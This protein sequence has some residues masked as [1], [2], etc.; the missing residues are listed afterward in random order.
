MEEPEEDRENIVPIQIYH[1]KVYSI[2]VIND[3]NVRMKKHVFLVSIFTWNAYI[4]RTLSSS[5]ILDNKY[6]KIWNSVTV[7]IFR[8]HSLD[9]Q[10][11]NTS[12]LRIRN[13]VREVLG[14]GKRK[15]DFSGVRW[16]RSH[17]VVMVFWMPR[18]AY[19]RVQSVKC[20]LASLRDDNLLLYAEIWAW[21][22]SVFYREFRQSFDTVKLMKLPIV[23][24]LWFSIS[25]T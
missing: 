20:T 16:G 3:V 12:M 13:W 23:E 19:N 17:Q 24:Y 2:Q 25:F 4:Y 9:M 5:K 7:C 1:F 10:L 8:K 21:T 11:F 15:V 18:G 22:A 14:K 6:K